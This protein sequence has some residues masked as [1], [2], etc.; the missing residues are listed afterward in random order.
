MRERER[1]TVLKDSI[2]TVFH[3]DFIISVWHLT[4]LLYFLL[5]E[6]YLTE[7]LPDSVVV[8]RLVR[9]APGSWGTFHALTSSTVTHYQ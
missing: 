5:H 7:S 3:K 1:M 2:T 4:C 9:T 8:K 6:M